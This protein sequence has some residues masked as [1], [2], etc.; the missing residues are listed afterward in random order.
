MTRVQIAIDQLRE[1]AA[2]L[3]GNDPLARY[4]EQFHI[5]RG[6]DGG[7]LAYLCGNSLG[8]APRKARE[9]VDRELLAWEQL[10]VEGHFKPERPWVSFHE[11]FTDHLCRVVGGLPHEVVAMNTLTVNL[12]LMLT[13]FYRPRPG[14]FRILVGHA[15]FPSDRYAIH[16]Q[17]ALHGFSPHDALVTASPRPGEYTLRTDDVIELIERHR[18]EILLVLMDGVN[19]Y[20]GE[21]IDISVITAAAHR[22]EILAGFDLAHAAGNVPLALH[23]WGVDF[24]VWCSYKYLNGGPGCVAGGFVHERHGLRADPLPRLAGWWG[25]DKR[26]RFAMEPD[27]VPIPGA[28][29]WQVSN[30]PLFSL[31]ALMTSLELFSEVG[32]DR[33]RARSESLTGFL[34][35]ALREHF[36]DRVD[37][38]TPVDPARRG[39]QLSVRVK[40]E[41]RKTFTAM[42]ERGVVCDWRE[43]DVIRLAPVPLYNRFADVLRSVELFDQIRREFGDA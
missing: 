21:F 28:E 2:E 37:V 9:Y 43:P 7:E 24:A 1:R 38:I 29:G 11:L 5:P 39:C 13:S 12:H 4:R 15:A 41:A 25:H 35:R 3:D 23:D 16:S 14:R 40:R 27:F 22:H 17:L 30:P 42:L 26:T 10:G 34:D 19:Y 18:S 20:T 32:I 8:L 6:P 33:L 36:P 31:A